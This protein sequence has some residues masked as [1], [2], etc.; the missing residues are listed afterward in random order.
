MS[1]AT[2][3]E[4]EELEA[5]IEVYC[6]NMQCVFDA[7]FSLKLFVQEIVKIVPHWFVFILG[8]KAV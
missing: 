3:H 4:R 5:E 7:F 1:I 2:G 6:M 8:K